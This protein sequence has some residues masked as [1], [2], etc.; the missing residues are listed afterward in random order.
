MKKNQIYEVTGM[1]NY[2]FIVSY[3]GARYEGWQR[4]VRTGET[5]QGKMESAFEKVTGE[6][7]QVIG[8]GRTDAGVHALG[9][10]ANVHMAKSMPLSELQDKL[11]RALPDDISISHMEE[12]EERFHSRF[13]AKEKHYRYRIRISSEKNVFERR[14]VWQL[15][16]NLNIIAMRVAAGFLIGTH[17]FTSFCGN[18]HLKKSAVRTITTIEITER[19]GELRIDYRGDGFLQNMLRII[20]GTL[21]EIGEGK[22]RDTDISSILAARDR[23]KAGFTA[24]PQGLTLVE[25]LY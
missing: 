6:K 2:G 24:P 23:S 5:I 14:Y 22:K 3:D 16:E 17:D 1:I 25:V 15:G 8:A 18:K 21:V 4:Q 10:Y 19:D 7:V 13:S 11:N 12:K 9:Q 20:T